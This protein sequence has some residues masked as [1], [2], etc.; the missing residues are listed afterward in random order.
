MVAGD[1]CKFLR[2]A[3]LMST[4]KKGSLLFDLVPLSHVE[5]VF[6]GTN[7]CF[8]MTRCRNNDSKTTPAKRDS[9]QKKSLFAW[10]MNDSYQL[11]LENYQNERVVR[12]PREITSIDAGQVETIEA[13]QQHSFF[14]LKSGAL[15]GVGLN[16]DG[17]IGVSANQGEANLYKQPTLLRTSQPVVWVMASKH[18]NYAWLNDGSLVS[19]GLGCSYVLG[20][21]LETVASSCF[22]IP[23]EY[24]LNL[25]GSVAL[26]GSHIVF[27]EGI[28]PLNNSRKLDKDSLPNDN[29]NPR[30]TDALKPD[31][32]TNASLPSRFFSP[33]RSTKAIK[34]MLNK[35][36]LTVSEDKS[37]SGSAF[38]L[39]RESPGFEEES[40][41]KPFKRVK[42]LG[43]MGDKISAL[44][45]V[46]N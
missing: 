11:G 31:L 7:H 1:G 36:S 12:F 4:E 38:T 39:K 26:G 41:Y 2:S 34:L 18:F 23:K 25:V 3:P 33:T 28:N 19:W 29:K 14:L 15:Y 30:N 43:G 10:G 8:A 16:E 22:K 13:G 32:D 27:A 24:L 42:Q 21:H 46:N 20:N 6:C 45:T 37:F 44:I 40:M 35:R 9:T 5:D 17:Q